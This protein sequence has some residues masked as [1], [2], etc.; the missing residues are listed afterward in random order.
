MKT[1]IIEK[2]MKWWSRIAS[3]II[4]YGVFSF[5][6]LGFKFIG[7]YSDTQETRLKLASLGSYIPN[8]L[9]LGDT[10]L[11]LLV[12][13]FSIVFGL[14]FYSPFFYYGWVKDPD[15]ESWKSFTKIMSV[16][17]VVVVLGGSIFN[18]VGLLNNIMVIPIV[19]VLIAPWYYYGWKK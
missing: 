12:I 14:I 4:V 3:L 15:S 6:Y 11:T 13:I 10:T 2:I 18:G 8:T 5:I 16:V 7:L 1:S 17:Y 9:T 19:L